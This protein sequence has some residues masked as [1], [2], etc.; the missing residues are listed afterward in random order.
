MSS[1][2]MQ[3]YHDHKNESKYFDLVMESDLGV[4]QVG[5]VQSSDVAHLPVA[6]TDSFFC[7]TAHRDLFFW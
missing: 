2:A 1:G 3:Y 5:Q 6:V 7:C 4:F